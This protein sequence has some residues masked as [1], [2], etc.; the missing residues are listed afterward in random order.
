MRFEKYEFEKIKSKFNTESDYIFQRME[1][2]RHSDEYHS[3]DFYEWI[4]VYEGEYVQL[5]NEKEYT[6]RSN[7]CMLICPGDR[8][9]LLR[10]SDKIKLVIF[11]VHAREMNTFANA[12]CI[13]SDEIKLFSA[14]FDL[15]QSRIMYDFFLSD[16]LREYKLLLSN[17]IKIYMDASDRIN[18]VPESLRLAMKEMLRVENLHKGISRFSEISGYSPSQLGRLMKKYYNITA[19]EYVKNTRLETAYNL[20]VS[21]KIHPEEIS[22][23]LGYSSFS[24]FNKIFT[25]KYGVTPAKVRKY[26]I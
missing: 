11:S 24:H 5:V 2:W 23:S 7:S 14:N 26:R 25:Q 21:T 12:F 22:E 16:D 6:L 4:I 13:D 18:I 3:H 10:Q 17:L 15:R 8:H 1:N 20:L 19:Y 9:M